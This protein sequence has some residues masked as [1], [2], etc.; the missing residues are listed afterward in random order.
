MHNPDMPNILIREMTEKDFL[1]CDDVRRRAGWNQT[2]RDWAR[3]LHLSP[4]GCF[5]AECDGAPA[6][7][8]TTISYST[9]I[10]W[11]GMLLTHPDFRRR[12]IATKLLACAIKSL[13]DRD[14]ECIGLDA[15]PE[16]FPLYRKLGFVDEWPL[17]RWEKAGR[18]DDLDGTTVSQ[19]VIDTLSEHD[20]AKITDLDE[21][22]FGANR[23]ALLRELSRDAHVLAY[24]EGAE[25]SAFG[26]LTSGANAHHLGPVV[27][28]TPAQAEHLIRALFRS[29]VQERFYWDIPAGN[30]AAERLAQDLGF[31]LQR[32]LIRMYL[33]RTCGAGACE[34]YFAVADPS[35]G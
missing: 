7:T 32:P 28:R 21:G 34:R 2:I 33:N 16:G 14:M 20:L 35:L 9:R 3:F 18:M 15:T 11:I 4:A 5:I 27:A 19:S 30:A 6:G 10:G 12:G 24:K 26:M 22:A 25:M 31:R 29:S 13:Q 8:I 1:F 17:A 23:F